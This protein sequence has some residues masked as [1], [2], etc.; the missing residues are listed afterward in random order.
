MAFASMGI[1][2]SVKSVPFHNACKTSALGTARNI[3]LLPYLE[4]VQGNF[5]P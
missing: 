5:L 4:Y 1:R 2:T 3:D